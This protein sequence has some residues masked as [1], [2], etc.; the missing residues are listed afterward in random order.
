V[1]ELAH[2]PVA[3]PDLAAVVADPAVLVR[4]PADVLIALR[5]Q[6]QHLDVEIALAVDRTRLQPTQDRQPDD[7]MILTPAKLAA[8]WGMSSAKV[9]ELCRARLIPARKMGPKEWLIPVAALREWA[10]ENP[11]AAQVTGGYNGS[12]ETPGGQAAPPKP[13]PYRIEVRRPTRLP[14]RHA[15]KMGGRAQADQSDGR[16]VSAALGPTS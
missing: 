16:E 7:I 5:A 10:R 8:F 1:S 6:L 4:L 15:A 3:V 9:R 14:S 12:Y 13:R 2:L 11:L